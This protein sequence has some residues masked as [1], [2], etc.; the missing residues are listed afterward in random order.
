M[1]AVLFFYTARD[2]VGAILDTSNTPDVTV[3][4]VGKQWSWDFNYVEAGTRESGTQ[5]ELTGPCRALRRTLPCALPAGQQ[6][7]RVRPDLP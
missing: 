4:V 5:A 1:I 6:A 7:G 2:D 3:N